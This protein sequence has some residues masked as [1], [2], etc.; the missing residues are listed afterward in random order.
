MYKYGIILNLCTKHG[1][2]DIKQHN[3]MKIWPSIRLNKICVFNMV[4]F[5][6]NIRF[7]S[8]IKVNIMYKYGIYMK[9][10]YLTC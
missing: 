9:S 3:E 8:T 5:K 6:Y 4:N 1:K 7:I 10:V 2:H